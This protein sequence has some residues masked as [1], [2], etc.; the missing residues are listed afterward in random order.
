M[1]EHRVQVRFS[2]GGHTVTAV[3]VFDE[4]DHLVDVTSD[5]R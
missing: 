1:D 2:Q 5:D 4:Q 3:L